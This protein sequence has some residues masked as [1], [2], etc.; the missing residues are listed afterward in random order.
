MLMNPRIGGTPAH[1]T[2][3]GWLQFLMWNNA[4]R[5][6]RGD[7]AE[8]RHQESRE[9]LLSQDHIKLMSYVSTGQ[10]V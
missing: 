6:N 3:L 5:S 4:E 9:F 8:H 1:G 2:L 10:E 7:D